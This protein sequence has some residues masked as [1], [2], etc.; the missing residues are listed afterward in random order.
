MRIYKY[1]LDY[2]V[3]Q[4][5]SLPVGYRILKL[6]IQND[7]IVFWALINPDNQK[8]DVKFYLYGTGWDIKNLNKKEYVGT[9]EAKHELIWHIFKEVEE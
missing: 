8:I 9:V 4:K 5:I 7:N 2:E 6:S 1:T 3:V